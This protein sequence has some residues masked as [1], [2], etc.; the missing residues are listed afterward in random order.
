MKRIAPLCLLAIGLNA[1]SASAAILDFEDLQTREDFVALA[2][3]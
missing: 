2:G 3:C 1:G